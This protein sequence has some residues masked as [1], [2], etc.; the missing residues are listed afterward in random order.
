VSQNCI[1]VVKGWDIRRW[2]VA[3]PWVM[4]FIN[5]PTSVPIFAHK[6]IS[7]TLQTDLLQSIRYKRGKSLL[8]N[9]PRG[10]FDEL[11]WVLLQTFDCDGSRLADRFNREREKRKESSEKTLNNSIK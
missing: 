5:G 3:S 7:W 6:V 4:S 10:Q 1:P 8:V 11:C 2:K 9:R